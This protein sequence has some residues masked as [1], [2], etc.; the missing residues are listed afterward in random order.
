MSAFIKDLIQCSSLNPECC[1]H[2]K[3]RGASLV[4][5]RKTLPDSTFQATSLVLPTHR[6]LS[7]KIGNHENKSLVA[8]DPTCRYEKQCV[9]P[10]L[11]TM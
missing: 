7:S 5:F 10:T 1:T 2:F 8:G 9:L 3:Q 6:A 11:G 4:A